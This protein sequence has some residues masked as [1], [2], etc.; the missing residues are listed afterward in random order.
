[1]VGIPAGSSKGT[2]A[3][4][5]GP[6]FSLALEHLPNPP[7]V[8]APACWLEAN[9]PHGNHVERETCLHQPGSPSDLMEGTSSPPHQPNPARLRNRRLSREGPGLCVCDKCPGA[10]TFSPASS[11][12]ELAFHLGT[13][14]SCQVG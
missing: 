11:G 8:P 14:P 1:M 5:R 6:P 2:W 12:E 9:L 13:S 3:G 7:A 4:M 10:G